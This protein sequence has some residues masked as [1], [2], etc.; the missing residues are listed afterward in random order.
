MSYGV[1]KG[2]HKGLSSPIVVAPELTEAGIGPVLAWKFAQVVLWVNDEATASKIRS[3]FRNRAFKMVVL[4]GKTEPQVWDETLALLGN[5]SDVRFL[6]ADGQSVP[7]ERP[8]LTI[9]RTVVNLLRLSEEAYLLELG[10]EAGFG[11]SD[12]AALKKAVDQAVAL[13]SLA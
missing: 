10:G 6:T 11:V 1:R 9:A 12:P 3:A 4:E 5:P 8:G 13:L 2:L 7:S